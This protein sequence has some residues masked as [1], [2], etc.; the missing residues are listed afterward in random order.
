M[1]R[2]AEGESDCLA[3][4]TIEFIVSPGT[5]AYLD[6]FT[7]E[8]LPPVANELETWGSVKSMYR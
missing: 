1:G 4:H 6:N 2:N 7:T 8:Y 5:V 3:G